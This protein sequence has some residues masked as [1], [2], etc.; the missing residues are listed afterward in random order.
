MPTKSGLLMPLFQLSL[1]NYVYMLDGH[2][3]RESEEK[4]GLGY[5]GGEVKIAEEYLKRGAYTGTT[6]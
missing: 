6:T 3:E 5:F 2:A 4:G 1:S